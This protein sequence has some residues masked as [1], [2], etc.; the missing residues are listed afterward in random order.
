MFA[1]TLRGADKLL[2]AGM[3]GDVFA[4]GPVSELQFNLATGAL[5]PGFS[6]DGFVE[7]RDA[8]ELPLAPAMR[9]AGGTDTLVIGGYTSSPYSPVARPLLRAC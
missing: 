3:L 6:G 1:A 8:G 7:R 2:V 5:D 9:F 4:Q